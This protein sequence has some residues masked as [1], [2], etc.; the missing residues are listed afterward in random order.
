[1]K[2]LVSDNGVY[3]LFVEILKPIQDTGKVQLKFSSQWL[4]AK[5]SDD[6]QTKFAADLSPEELQRLKNFL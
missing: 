6:F 5:N 1:M 2:T 4:D 3:K